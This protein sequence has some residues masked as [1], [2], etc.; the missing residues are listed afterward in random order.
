MPAMN[1]NARLDAT[2]PDD[3]EVHNVNSMISAMYMRPA[4][5]DDLDKIN[6]VI[7]RAVMTWNLPDRV[8]RLSLPSYHYD[9]LDL[10]HFRILLAF[11]DDRLAGVIALD[12]EHSGEQLAYKSILIHGL[13]VVPELQHKGIGTRLFQEAERVAHKQ[14]TQHLIVKAHKDATGFFTAMGMTKLA[15]TDEVRNYADRYRKRIS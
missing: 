8:K 12:H 9:K 6:Q 11:I 7:T 1:G 15:V 14:S 2:L 10:Q 5:A 3:R 4:N 13:F